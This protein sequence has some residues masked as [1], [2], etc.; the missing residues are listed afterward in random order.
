MFYQLTFLLHLD[1]LLLIP[2]LTITSK[3]VHHYL[4][5]ILFSAAKQHNL[6]HYY[7]MRKASDESRPI[8]IHFIHS[9]TLR[10]SLRASRAP[11][12]RVLIKKHIPRMHP[13]LNCINVDEGIFLWD[14]TECQKYVIK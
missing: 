6:A 12:T 8:R 4:N 1:P 14:L 11:T 13:A 7:K 3:L 2:V 9:L 10:E 5:I